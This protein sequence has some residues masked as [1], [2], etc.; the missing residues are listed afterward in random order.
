MNSKLRL[1]APLQKV[2][3]QDDG[4]LVVTGYATTESVDSAGEVVLAK[5]IKAALPDF[6][7]HGSGPL[8]EMHQLSAAGIVTE[9][10]IDSQNRT[11][12]VATVVDEAAIKKCL[13]GVYVGFSIGG[14]TLARDPDDRKVITKIRLDEISLVDRPANG[15]A[16]LLWK[17]SGA[18]TEAEAVAA[19][20]AAMSA[21]ERAMAITKAALAT[22]HRIGTWK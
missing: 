9:A 13:K 22:P 15:E 4:T 6:F 21:D 12:I 16:V 11:R 2:D 7:K 3:E 19:A 18:L 10:E 5:A 1:F 20:L 14:K 8:R 17:A